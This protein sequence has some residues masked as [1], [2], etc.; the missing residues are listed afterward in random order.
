APGRATATGRLTGAANS[1]SGAPTSPATLAVGA[2]T[3]QCRA[4]NANG[5]TRTSF[6][7]TVVDHEPPVLALPADVTVT[8]PAGSSTAP[9]DFS[10]SASDNVAVRS[11]VCD[12][13]SG[14]R[15]AYGLTT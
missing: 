11:I 15:F 3:V 9:V 8:A 12:P 2:N 1:G 6:V 14:T 13:R 10:V 7:V 4:T 5:T